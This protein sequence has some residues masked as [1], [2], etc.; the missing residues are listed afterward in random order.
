[1]YLGIAIARRFPR[2]ESL[3]GASR[4]CL[5]A[6]SLGIGRDSKLVWLSV[7]SAFTTRLQ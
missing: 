3:P 7:L 6:D 2:A 5:L 4:G 1:M